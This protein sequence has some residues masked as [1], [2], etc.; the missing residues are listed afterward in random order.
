MVARLCSV[1]TL[2]SV[3]DAAGLISLAQKNTKSYGEVSGS[4][5]SGTG[6]WLPY[7]T[8]YDG[9]KG[10]AGTGDNGMVCVVKQICM[11]ERQPFRFQHGAYPALATL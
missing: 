11:V 7:H 3:W 1:C 9:T 8:D 2:V 6:G 10:I 5:Y 4:E